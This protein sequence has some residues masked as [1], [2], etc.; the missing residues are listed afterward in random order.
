MDVCGRA[1]FGELFDFD[2]AFCERAAECGHHSFI[3]LA[4]ALD[5]NQE[6]RNDAM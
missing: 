1:A 3:I 5:I 2:E 6:G 4:G